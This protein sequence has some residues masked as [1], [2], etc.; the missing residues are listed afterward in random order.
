MAEYSALKRQFN[1]RNVPYYTFHPKSLKPVKVVIRQLP[2]DTPAKDSTNELV[3]LSYSVIS[4]RQM[5]A[6]RPQPQGAFKP[7]TSHYFL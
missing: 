4:D 7:S 1:A 3:A 5:T 6:T 2:E